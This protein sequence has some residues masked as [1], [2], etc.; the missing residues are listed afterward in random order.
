[1]QCEIA[2]HDAFFRRKADAFGRWLRGRPP[3]RR[4]FLFAFRHFHI[5]P[6]ELRTGSAGTDDRYFP[7][8]FPAF[9]I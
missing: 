6:N 3:P 9:F 1:M 4:H 7:R 8:Y 2:R 5:R